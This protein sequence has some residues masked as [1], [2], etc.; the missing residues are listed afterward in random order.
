MQKT[1]AGLLAT[2]FGI[3]TSAMAVSFTDGDFAG[4][5]DIG[6]DITVPVYGN[7]WQWGGQEMTSPSPVQP[8]R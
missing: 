5:V 2:A 7:Y 3:S 6:G 4:G 8:V 1:M